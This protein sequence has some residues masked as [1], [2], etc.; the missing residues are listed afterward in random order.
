MRQNHGYRLAVPAPAGAKFVVR[1]SPLTADVVEDA[2]VA[3]PHLV[4]VPGPVWPSIAMA[5]ASAKRRALPGQPMFVQRDADS[6]LVATVR[7]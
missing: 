5:K 2:L 4:R 7:A 6:A 1:T 3:G